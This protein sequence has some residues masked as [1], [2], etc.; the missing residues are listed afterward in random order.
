MKKTDPAIEERID[1]II[2]QMTLDEK[3]AYLGGTGFV[4][5]EKIGETL[6]IER[7]GLPAFK[8]TDATMGS[9]L[10]KS[11]TLFP[12]YI[13]QAAAF[14]PELAYDF[15]QAVAEECIADGFRILLGPGVNIYRLPNCGRNFE[16]SGEDPYLAARTVVEYIKGVQDTGVIATVKHFAANNT[17]YYRRNSNSV[18]DERTLR[19]IYFPAFK[20]AVQ[21]AD[22][23]AVM[24]SYN[25]INGIWAAE[26]KWLI[27]D[28][29][30]NEWGFNRL[31]MTDWWGVTNTD[32]L[33][34][35]GTDIEMPEPDILKAEKVKPLLESG[36]VTEAYIEQRIANVLRP[37]FEMGLFDKPHQDTSMRKKWAAH[38][39][40]ARKIAREGLVLLKN[41][42]ILPLDRK[43]VKRIALVGSNAEKTA[44]TGQGAAGF[45]PGN[46]FVT[47]AQAIRQ[48]AGDS[49]K[50]YTATP[51][52]AKDAD[53]ALVFATL[54][55]KE[56]MDHPFPFPADVVKMINDT[57]A[58]NPNTVVIVSL[59]TGVDMSTWIDTV[60]GLVYPWY[61]GTH[62][63]VALGEMLFGDL[64]PSGKLPITIEKRPEDTHY[65]GNY[66]PEGAELGY[67]FPGW[68]VKRPQYDVHYR[69][70]V[71]VGYRW[72][73]TK[74]IEP[75]FPFGF[76][77]S[78]TTF[79]FDDIKLSSHTL[80]G[81]EKLTMTF[82]L[83]NTGKVDGSQVAQLY[84]QDVESS[85]LRPA[86]ELKGFKKVFLK[87][88]QTKSV[89]LTIDKT[90]L[91]FWDEKSKQWH[92]EPGAFKAL[93][94]SSSRDIE[95]EAQF[96]Y[97]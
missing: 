17:D 57:A 79:K 95:L 42:G 24:A 13:C 78:Y 15:G 74:K 61:P 32:L 66:L 49:I 77:L 4:N 25:L 62:G 28:I 68:D 8:M 70:G 91:S 11:A 12:P 14:D 93:V 83:T 6:G 52:E 30:R 16:Y 2:N 38:A 10:T 75:M 63:S 53:V 18:V 84:V 33:M 58:V 22:S 43:T 1:A 7:I 81:D 76:G 72:F 29:L 54:L 39:K 48:S 65:F 5:G 23:K 47:Y 85:V 46:D 26:N 3:I 44:A 55:E 41:D 92:A 71:L 67:E 19:E 87:A 45:A 35:S 90:A 20:A 59:G 40:V 96:A 50:V 9:K 34:A 82:N 73:D 37:C 89:E 80:S 27:T 36:Q 86:K 51:Q 56:N 69:E 21:E 88:G 60:K 94:G 97:Q 31:V 64:N